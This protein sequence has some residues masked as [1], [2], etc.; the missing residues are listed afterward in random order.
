METVRPIFHQERV[1][2]IEQVEYQRSDGLLG[3]RCSAELHNHP[4]YERRTAR[5]RRG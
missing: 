5:N 3:R 1:R 4:L 2:R